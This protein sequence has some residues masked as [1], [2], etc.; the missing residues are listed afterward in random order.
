AAELQQ[1]LSAVRKEAKATAGF[2]KTI[3]IVAIIAA[4]IPIALIFFFAGE[5]EAPVAPAAT[6]QV[7]PAPAPTE[8]EAAV[9][10]EPEAVAEE[11][12]PR[13]QPEPEAEPVEA[14]QAEA[15]QEEPA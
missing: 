8:P 2:D 9:A 5:D 12:A 6:E 10:A 11:E 13:A 1:E 14:P 7:A 4:L 3:V 15:P